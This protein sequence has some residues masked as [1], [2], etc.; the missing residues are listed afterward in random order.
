MFQSQSFQRLESAVGWFDMM[1][2]S[3]Q[4]NTPNQE[5]DTLKYLFNIHNQ[6]KVYAEL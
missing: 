2:K 6:V 4:G 5:T 1:D 3:A